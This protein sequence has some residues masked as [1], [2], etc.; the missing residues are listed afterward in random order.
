MAP[1][2]IAEASDGQ[3]VT[4]TGTLSEVIDSDRPGERM[5]AAVL[6]CPDG[7]VRAEVWPLPFLLYSHLV[8]EGARVTVHGT[9]DRSNALVL[10]ADH[11]EPAAV[12]AAASAAETARLVEEL[13]AT[14]RRLRISR[15][16]VAAR[17]GVSYQAVAAWENGKTQPTPKHLAAWR[18]ALSAFERGK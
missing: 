12:P 13:T 11:I 1:K 5:A 14:R 6:T 4:V 8:T 18:S 15:P 2:E 3:S 10:R 16:A 7:T 17:V 9:V